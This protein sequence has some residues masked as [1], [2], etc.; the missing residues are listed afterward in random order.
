[1][2]RCHCHL[3]PTLVGQV[4][5]RPLITFSQE[6][7]F[8]HPQAT[9]V[10]AMETNVLKRPTC[11]GKHR[12][13]A[14]VAKVQLPLHPLTGEDTMRPKIT[15]VVVIAL[16]VAASMFQVLQIHIHLY[17]VYRTE[18]VVVSPVL[19]EQPPKPQPSASRRD[20]QACLLH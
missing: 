14:L 12:L 13:G 4:S 1:M 8:L 15:A 19:R 3:A 11:L 18:T 6:A 10:Q 16:T 2:Y 7:R 17:Q 9:S 20:I 5:Y